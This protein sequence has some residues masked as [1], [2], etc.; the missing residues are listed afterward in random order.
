MENKAVVFNKEKTIKESTVESTAK[1]TIEKVEKNVSDEVGKNDLPK[2]D[3]SFLDEDKDKVD[4]LL[5]DLNEDQL[6]AF[7]HAIIHWQLKTSYQLA[8][9]LLGND[10]SY[11]DKKLTDQIFEQKNSLLEKLI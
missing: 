8:E 1:T 4:I 7:C 6:D 10:T 3:F 11:E 2:S 9:E 5:K